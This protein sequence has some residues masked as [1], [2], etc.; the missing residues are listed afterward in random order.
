MT[1]HSEDSFLGDDDLR[2][3]V[4]SRSHT[5]LGIYSSPSE[6]TDVSSPPISPVTVRAATTSPKA[7]YRITV[8]PKIQHARKLSNDEAYESQEGVNMTDENSNA[9]TFETLHEEHVDE[10]YSHPKSKHLSGFLKKFR[11]SGKRKKRSK[12]TDDS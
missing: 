7:S 9:M 12:S 1:S 5:A 6:S 2:V 3:P 10:K 4:T 11:S 8:S